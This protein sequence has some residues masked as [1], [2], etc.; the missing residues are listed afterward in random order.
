MCI[1]KLII[2]ITED[3][4]GTNKPFVIENSTHGLIYSPNYP[5]NYPNGVECSWLV[6]IGEGLRMTINIDFVDVERG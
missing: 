6:K 4:C 2:L 3:P 5:N 1:L